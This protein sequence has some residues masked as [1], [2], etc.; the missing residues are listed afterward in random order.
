MAKGIAESAALT[1]EDREA[2]L[3][4]MKKAFRVE[5]IKESM[6]LAMVKHFTAD[7][8]NALADFYSTPEGQA[9]L[10]KMGSYMGDLMPIIQAEAEHALH[11]RMQQEE[12]RT[13]Q[14]P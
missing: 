13:G 4:F 14:Q 9:V 11:L 3:D 5:V 2:F 1:G 10:R 7:E 8:L 6:L 12:D